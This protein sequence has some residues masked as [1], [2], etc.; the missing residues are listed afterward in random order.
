[1]EGVHFDLSYSS[2]YSLGWKVLAMNMSDCSAM[3]GIAREALVTVGL[4]SGIDVRDVKKIYRGM[5]VLA[6][7]HGIDIVGGDTVSSPRVMIISVTLL[8]E[9]KRKD[10]LLRSGAKEGDLILTTG[11]LGDSAAGLKILQCRDNPR[12]CPKLRTGASP[13][14][15]LLIKRHLM[16][17]P[18]VK[19]GMLL[20]RSK[21]ITSMIDNSDGLARCV[22]EIC[23][24]SGVGARISLPSIPISDET[25]AF[26]RKRGIDAA[27]LALN[28]GED[29]ELVFTVPR[30][31]VMR[32]FRLFKN[33]AEAGLAVVGE[34]TKKSAG[35]KVID[36]K[37][38]IGPLKASG[39]DH[40]RGAG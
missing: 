20:V 26:C 5:D 15:T 11:Y 13:V 9:V 24:M 25:L 7:R 28:G 12:G 18:R 8:G 16:P 10:L 29:Y 17:E 30:S 37:G 6:K 32:L 27:D 34:I 39:Y 22:I 2:L 1:V 31:K 4:P 40:F 14:P 33:N 21:C 38:R 36:E 35:I 3:G 23:R 19:E